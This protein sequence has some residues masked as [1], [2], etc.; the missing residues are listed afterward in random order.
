MISE[1]FPPLA[2]IVDQILAGLSQ[3]STTATVIG[4]IVAGWGTSRVFASLQS[5]IVQLETTSARRSFVR[6]T[7]RRIG[8]IFVVAGILLF[9]LLLSPILSILRGQTE[10]PSRATIVAVAEVI[11]PI[12]LASLALGVVYRVMPIIRPSPRAVAPAAVLGAVALDILSR[13]FVFF[14]P[15]LF[16]GNVVYGTLGAIL[17]GLVW[18]QLVF[19]IILIGAAWTIERSLDLSRAASLAGGE[20][21]GRVDGGVPPP[22]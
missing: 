4:L 20:R 2:P 14:A 10:D 9:S 13:G 15:R 7:A 6:S 19:M 5:A 22:V 16:A 1:L 17:V 3:T 21:G 12:A 8:S 18:L 11:L